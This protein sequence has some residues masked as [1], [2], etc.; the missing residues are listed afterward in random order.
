MIKILYITDL[1]LRK[2]LKF[3]FLIL[4]DISPNNVF[5]AIH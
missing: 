3:Q 5:V 1:I 2:Q 4:I